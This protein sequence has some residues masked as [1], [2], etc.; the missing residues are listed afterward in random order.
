MWRMA[1]RTSRQSAAKTAQTD[2][3]TSYVDEARQALRN[4]DPN[5]VER[6]QQTYETG[7][8]EAYRRKDFQGLATIAMFGATALH[9]Q[10]LHHE[11]VQQLHFAATM[12]QK[13]ATAA[14]YVLSLRAVYEAL[15]GE[16]A[17]AMATIDE[18]RPFIAQA[19]DRGRLGG[20]TYEACVS[21]IALS[22]NAYADLASP[23]TEADMSGYDWMSS[24]LRC[25]LIALQVAR[26]DWRA[27]QPWT[28]SLRI[29]A[30]T[31][32]HPARR[33][34]AVAFDLANHVLSGQLP[35][36][37]TLEVAI[38]RGRE[39]NNLIA[40]QRLLALRLRRAV[41]TGTPSEH[42]A[43]ELD[44][45][46]ARLDPAFRDGATGY[47]ALI[48]AYL[49]ESIE[50]LNPPTQLTLV[51]LGAVLAAMEAVA[52]AGTQTNAVEWL[53]WSEDHFPA[54]I[55]T[56]VEWPVSKLRVMGLLNLRAGSPVSGVALL[57]R[58]QAW[59]EAHGYRAEAALA[60]VVLGEA[61]T[62]GD[63]REQKAGE[64][65]AA[66]REGWQALEALGLPPVV[67]S[68]AATRALALR[69]DDERSP[70]LTPQETRVMALL[71][72]GMSYRQIGT[73][74]GISW[75]TAQLHANHIY[76][77]LGASGKMHAAELA[78]ELRVLPGTA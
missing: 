34:D 45:V 1:T 75:R 60:R 33:V 52:L 17:T 51:N 74:L 47:R 3:V 19:D 65:R 23:V 56:S 41:L 31:V 57:R 6:W 12:A 73:E 10:G 71:A 28:E 43:D 61:L 44:A 67:H 62:H 8:S 50:V 69:K 20:L 42:D 9:E 70:R 66:R 36:S 13:N 4:A 25:W 11:A 15:L 29:Q 40:L 37:E 27:S 5:D 49:G 35:E 46:V 54:H 55:E 14:A 32:N 72:Q 48:A 22:S 64:Q 59:G 2:D 78:R 21:A 63:I 76:S 38:E 30:E 68:Y 77:K 58:A 24:A 39:T 18:A 26:G 16:T 53:R 7:L